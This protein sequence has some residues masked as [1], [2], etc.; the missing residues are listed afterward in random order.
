[1]EWLNPAGAW[2]L[3][4][5][6]PVIVLYVLKHRA[7]RVDVPSLLLWRKTQQRAQQTS[8][9]QRLRNQLLL[10]L[11]LLMVLLLALA[12]MRPVTAG[13]QQSESVFIFV[14]AASMQTMGNDGLTRLENAKKQA[15]SLL[16]ACATMTPLPSLQQASLFR[17][18]FRAAP[19]IRWRAALCRR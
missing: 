13:G 18:R 3:L 6:I 14:L 16:D 17:S 11:Q 12:L 8:P 4:G 10:W 7:V 19:I 9:F 5:A 15:L 1:M 2:A